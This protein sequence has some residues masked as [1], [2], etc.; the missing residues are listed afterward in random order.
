MTVFFRNHPALPECKLVS[1]LIDTAHY[2]RPPESR[3]NLTGLHM[4]IEK[5]DFS[6]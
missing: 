5:L 3:A 2:L 6:W 4:I 1:E